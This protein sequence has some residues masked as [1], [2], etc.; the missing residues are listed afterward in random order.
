M[1]GKE[2]RGVPED[3]LENLERSMDTIAKDITNNNN[4]I[5]RLFIDNLDISTIDNGT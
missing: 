4:L 5:G 2:D 1:T 3:H